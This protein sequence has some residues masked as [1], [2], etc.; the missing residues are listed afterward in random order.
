MAYTKND[1]H[2]GQQV[3]VL[4]LNKLKGR[5][6]EWVT[7]TAEVVKI[8]RTFMYAQL[9]GP[10]EL[11]FDMETGLEAKNQRYKVFLTMN[12]YIDF[13]NTYILRPIV[14]RA[15]G[16]QLRTMN[17]DQLIAIAQILGVE[18]EGVMI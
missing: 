9:P 15:L 16:R 5:Q 8:G 2:V 1:Y 7:Y 17:V 10:W 14:K 4:N 13:H 18:Y 12:D 11:Q 3:I 6:I